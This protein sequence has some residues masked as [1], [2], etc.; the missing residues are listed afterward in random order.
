MKKTLLCYLLR[1]SCLRFSGKLI[2][3]DKAGMRWKRV[4]TSLPG[5]D[6]G[7]ITP[8]NQCIETWSSQIVQFPMLIK[9]FRKDF[10]S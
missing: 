5:S 2:F 10:L 8:S 3:L 4:Q 9:T 7:Q 6:V 1:K